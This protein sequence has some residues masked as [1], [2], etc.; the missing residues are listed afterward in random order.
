MKSKNVLLV[1]D[2][3]GVGKVALST[4]IPVLSTM[5]AKLSYLPTAVVSNNFDYGE[6]TLHDLTD[7]MRESKD[8][9]K[10]LEF[11]FDIIATGILMNVEQVR[12]VEEIINWHEKKP[13]VIVDPI[14][15]DEGSIYPGLSP[16]LVK[17]SRE[18]ALIGDV[19]I[20]NVTELS[21]IV[22]KEYPE[23]MTDE[24]IT[25]WLEKVMDR[26][27]KSTIVTSVKIGEKHYVYAYGEEGEIFRVEY[28]K[29]P[30]EVGG[31]GDL[32]TSLLIGIIEKGSSLK[33]AIEY[34]TRILSNIVEKEYE[35]GIRERINEL[36]LQKYLQ[37]IY[38][39][40]NK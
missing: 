16:D 30:L 20:P 26:G 38:E 15:G 32:F 22:G 12:I 7:F 14:M 18:A 3:V 35:S 24:I 34:A 33:E 13:L 28:R 23:T 10:K 19:I 1:S 11:K 21:L 25:S 2:F 37:Y 40:M 8:I 27:V 6:V 9:W 5:E 17:A 36:E 31:T 29:I 39:E 4:M